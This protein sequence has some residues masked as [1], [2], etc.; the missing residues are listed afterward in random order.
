[1]CLAGATCNDAGQTFERLVG[2]LGT[3][4]PGDKA[5]TGTGVCVE[6][7]GTACST[8]AQ[9]Q[10]GQFCSPAAT[11][12]REHGTCRKDGDCPTGSMGQRGLLM[13]T[14]ADTDGDE[15]PDVFDNCPTVANV[16]QADTNG[17]GVG[18][19]CDATLT[20]LP[21]T[22]L[23]TPATNCHVAAALKSSVTIV[24]N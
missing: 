18:D 7:F 14:A 17:D 1:D 19:A 20:A 24:D 5:F 3:E 6:D 13:A 21:A 9:C 8:N 10:H 23:P 22:C 16:D 4:R 11:C 12:E 2:P 15:I